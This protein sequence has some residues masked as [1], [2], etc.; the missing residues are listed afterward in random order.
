MLAPQADDEVVPELRASKPPPVL[1]ERPDAVLIIAAKNGDEVAF[2]ELY[3]RYRR[4][5]RSLAYKLLQDPNAADDA[6]QETMLRAFKWLPQM[7]DDSNLKAWL[8]RVCQN[9]CRD[10]LRRRR[11]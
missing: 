1:P 4:S 10:E 7:S 8:H 3:T 5:L 11:A 9:L 6:V 2:G